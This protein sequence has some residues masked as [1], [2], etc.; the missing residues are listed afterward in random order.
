MIIHL[1]NKSINTHKNRIRNV[2]RLY[3]ILLLHQQSKRGRDKSLSGG[4]FEICIPTPKSRNE[5]EK[6]MYY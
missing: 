2:N 6:L 3:F 5:I 1:L 4:N